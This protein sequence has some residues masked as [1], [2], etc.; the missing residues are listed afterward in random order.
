M[1][2]AFDKNVPKDTEHR[3]HEVTHNFSGLRGCG[4][5]KDSCHDV[6]EEEVG[7]GGERIWDAS[8]V[9]RE[10]FWAQSPRLTRV[11]TLEREKE[12]E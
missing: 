12:D 10:N 7:K 9:G 6:I 1:Y 5:Q 11:T 8:Q 4:T 2:V 3:N